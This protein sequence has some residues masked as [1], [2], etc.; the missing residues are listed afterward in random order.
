MELLYQLSYVGLSQSQRYHGATSP[1]KLAQAIFEPP[2]P[3]AIGRTFATTEPPPG[4]GLASHLVA[5]R[6]GLAT[7]SRLALLRETSSGVRVRQNSRR[8]FLSHLPDSNRGPSL[9]KRVA[10]PTE[11]RWL[12]PVL[13]LTQISLF[14]SLTATQIKRVAV[15]NFLRLRLKILNPGLGYCLAR[16]KQSY[17]LFA[18][19]S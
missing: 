10:L 6:F 8:R 12:D 7:A 13:K 17:L 15:S 14:L 19:L 4:R 3:I 11:L 16:E 9:Y 1:S 2:L 18:Q 5:T